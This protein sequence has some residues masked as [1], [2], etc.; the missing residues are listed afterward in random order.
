VSVDQA[1]IDDTVHWLVAA[2]SFAGPREV[3]DELC[4]RLVAA[5]CR[6]HRVAVFL[7]T[8]HPNVMGR[9]YQ[10]RSDGED[11]I[12]ILEP[13]LSFVDTDEFRASPI[14]ALRQSGEPIRRRLIDPDCPN[15]FA[16][17]QNLRDD[18]VT[19]YLLQPL[20]FTNGELQSISWNS[21]APD[22]FSPAELAA[23][24]AVRQP[25]ARAVEIYALRLT[26][27][28][29][30]DT[31]V[32]HG[33]GEQILTGRI[34]RGDLQEIEAV[35][36]S[37]DLE[38][39][40]GFSNSHDGGAVVARLNAFFDLLVPAIQAQGGEVLKFIGDGALAIFPLEADQDTRSRCAAAL[41][42]ARATTAAAVATDCTPPLRCRITL[43]LG[44][45]L[46]GNVGA[47][48]RLDFTAVGPAVNLASRL[49]GVAKATGRAIV[50]SDSFAAT[51]GDGFEPLGEFALQGYAGTQPVFAPAA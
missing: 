32:G 40:T 28:T 6:L 38:D 36:L 48:G 34:E 26:A 5:G 16:I 30:L 35:I 33:A 3:L 13:P 7:R 41:A 42:A 44:P 31:Y 39:S 12:D 37:A 9:R 43:H 19:D 1:K 22:G 25:L 11:A 10:W 49:D 4:E 24:E 51:I 18:G 27:V 8:L 2:R 45:V 46:Y 17:L 50:A 14:L 23:F 47:A 20:H 15:D 21:A 29:L